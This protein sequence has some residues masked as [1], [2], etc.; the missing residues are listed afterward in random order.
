M[1]NLVDFNNLL[2]VKQETIEEKW[3]EEGGREGK[4]DDKVGM[5]DKVLDQIELFMKMYKGIEFVLYLYTN[6]ILMVD[7]PLIRKVKNGEYKNCQLLVGPQSLFYYLGKN[8]AKIK[9]V[10]IVS[11]ERTFLSENFLKFY[12]NFNNNK[13]KE[14]KKKQFYVLKL[15][16]LEKKITRP[17][18]GLND[19]TISLNDEST[20][21]GLSYFSKSSAST[22][23]GRKT[24]NNL[25]KIRKEKKEETKEKSVQQISFQQNSESYKLLASESNSNV[26]LTLLDNDK[27]VQADFETREVQ[28]ENETN[29]EK[30]DYYSYFNNDGRFIKSTLEFLKKVQAHYKSKKE[31]QECSSFVKA[32]HN[33]FIQHIGSKFKT[34]NE[35]TDI[36]KKYYLLYLRDMILDNKLIEGE[37]LE[38]WKRNNKDSVEDMINV[39]FLYVNHEKFKEFIEFNTTKID[40]NANNLLEEENFKTLWNLFDKI[41]QNLLENNFNQVSGLTK[42]NYIKSLRN[43]M[44]NFQNSK[45]WGYLEKS[46]LSSYKWLEIILFKIL[47]EIKIIEWDDDN[48]LVFNDKQIDELKVEYSRGRDYN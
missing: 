26:N 1:K 7:R 17:S 13:I 28:K 9:E 12:E 35:L 15:N 18:N 27:W 19:D 44:T 14:K 10:Y 5:F 33:L 37:M 47:T 11:K 4:N 42:L 23:S 30:E 48:N 32:I 24:K 43:I 40:A 25:R 39:I 31:E 6:S 41:I 16:E 36:E 21:S 45:D 3:N 29:K 20:K 34:N 8:E 46:I 38:Y 2:G 22:S